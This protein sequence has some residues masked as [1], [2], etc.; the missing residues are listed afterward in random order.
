MRM[1]SMHVAAALAALGLAAFAP[2]CDGKGGTVTEEEKKNWAGSAPPPGFEKEMA[3]QN[4]EWQERD[5][6]ARAKLGE[7]A[8]APEGAKL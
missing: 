4:R 5:A 7:S 3:K 2:G 1:R 6:R 8:K